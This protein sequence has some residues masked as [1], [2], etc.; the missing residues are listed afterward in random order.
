MAENTIA[1]SGSEMING[2][3]SLFSSLLQGHPTKA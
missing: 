3:T 2:K 1:N